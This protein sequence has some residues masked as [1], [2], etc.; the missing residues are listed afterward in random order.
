MPCALVALASCS[1]GTRT[2][3]S[4]SRAARSYCRSRRFC[5]VCGWPPRGRAHRGADGALIDVVD[6]LVLAV[7]ELL[8]GFLGL[9]DD[10]LVDV[11]LR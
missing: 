10:I 6:V 7:V 4:A 3:G 11:P 5:G 8:A 1:P 9:I 2:R